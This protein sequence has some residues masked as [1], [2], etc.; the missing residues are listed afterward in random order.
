VQEKIPPLNAAGPVQPF[1]KLRGKPGQ[2]YVPVLRTSNSH[3]DEGI[4][5]FA[6][7]RLGFA[8]GSLGRC[9][10]FCRS[11]TGTIAPR[12]DVGWIRAHG[13]EG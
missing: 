2:P 8:F 13:G 4:E 9:G 5:V 6:Q 3:C 10:P 1:D 7:N 12:R 11:L